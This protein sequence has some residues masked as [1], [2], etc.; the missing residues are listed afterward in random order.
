M[1]GGSCRTWDSTD[2]WPIAWGQAHGSDSCEDSSTPVGW[3]GQFGCSRM[4]S[5]LY[6]L[7]MDPAT[8][9]VASA[10][11]LTAALQLLFNRLDAHR[12]RKAEYLDFQTALECLSWALLAWRRSAERTDHLIQEW[13]DGRGA[14]ED[15]VRSLLT[16]VGSQLMSS[17]EAF[18]LLQGEWDIADRMTRRRVDYHPKHED[19]LVRRRSAWQ[20]LRHLL[21]LYGPEVLEVLETAMG[22]R[23]ALLHQLSSELPNLR[24]KGPE[25]MQAT[26]E[27]LHLATEKLD[28]ALIMLDEYIRSNFSPIHRPGE[29]APGL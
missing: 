17:Q 14:D 27:R 12:K 9:A 29:P 21:H 23:R 10:T 26:A 4:A 25:A 22:R 18:A 19:G 20:S 3:R 28:S 11:A 8:L 24:A 2:G 16:V 1:R 6:H 15:R 7:A 13:V 5:G